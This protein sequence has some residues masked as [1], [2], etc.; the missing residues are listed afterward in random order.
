MGAHKAGVEAD[1]VVVGIVDELG[2]DAL[3][4]AG[5]GPSCEALVRRLVLAVALGQ[6]VP[7]RA[8]AKYPEHAVDEIEIV[9]PRAA[10]ITGLAGQ[11]IL[12]PAPLFKAQFVA[13]RF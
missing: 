9:S 6:V 13:L 3:P 12:D 7:V 5:L 8:R 11:Q 10:R 2:E 4:N 1:I